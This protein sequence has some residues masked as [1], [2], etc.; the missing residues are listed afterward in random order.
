MTHCTLSPLLTLVPLISNNF[1]L[2]ENNKS[3]RRLWQY[4]LKV[5]FHYPSNETQELNSDIREFESLA[6]RVCYRAISY[7]IAMHSRWTA[8]AILARNVLT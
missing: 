4:F 6:L 5:T 2:A 1:G 8:K 7:M 3:S